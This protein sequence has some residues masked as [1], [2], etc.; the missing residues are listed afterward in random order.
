MRQ[1]MLTDPIAMLAVIRL[2]RGMV[3]AAPSPIAVTTAWVDNATGER[4]RKQQQGNQCR[5][6]MILRKAGARHLLIGPC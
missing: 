6:H 4:K 1:T 2:E 5:F 3:L